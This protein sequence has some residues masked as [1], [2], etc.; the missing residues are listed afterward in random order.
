MIQKFR[1]TQKLDDSIV[2]FSLF[3]YLEDKGGAEIKTQLE[4]ALKDGIRSFVLDFRGIELIS[5]PGV[6]ALLDI[7]SRVVDDFD[8]RIA[9]YGL[10]SHHLAVL[11]MAGLFYLMAQAQDESSALSNCRE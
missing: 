10:D 1:F 2:V 5:S 6:A 7:A 4:K 3:G 11:E 9:G 8:G